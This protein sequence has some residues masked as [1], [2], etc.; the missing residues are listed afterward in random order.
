MRNLIK[1]YRKVKQLTKATRNAGKKVVKKYK[2]A[3]YAK[4]NIRNKPRHSGDNDGNQVIAVSHGKNYKKLNPKM[5]SKIRSA[6][7]SNFQEIYQNQATIYQNVRGA[8]VVEAFELNRTTHIDNFLASGGTTA[9]GAT[10]NRAGKINLANSEME[11]SLTNQANTTCLMKVYEY[12]YRRDLPAKL[13][14]G[15]AFQNAD[16][17]YVVDNGTVFY[18]NSGGGALPATVTYGQRLFDNPLFTSYCKIL[19]CKDYELASGKNMM[20]KMSDKRDHHINT[21]LWDQT[22]TSAEGGITRGYVIEFRSSSVANE[23]HTDSATGLVKIDAV[24]MCRYQFDQAW[25]GA[26]KINYYDGLSHFTGNAILMNQNTGA[27]INE[28][29]V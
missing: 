12:V 24:V 18:N 26:N 7:N 1:G 19:S 25:S 4:K 15:V 3:K 29:V 28:T 9:T 23:A 16:T 21:L 2:V 5:E 13:W 22:D 27:V 14:D 11:V 6:L 8:K 17:K 20:L 10:L